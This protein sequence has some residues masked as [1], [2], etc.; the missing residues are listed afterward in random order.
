MSFIDRLAHAWNVF[1]NKDPT[2]NLGPSYYVRP[3][4]TRYSRGNERSIVTAIFN[5][6]AMDASAIDIRHVR[7]DDEGRFIEYVDSELDK[8]LTIEANIDQSGRSFRQDIY[9]SL[10]DEGCIGIVPVE[11]KDSKINGPNLYDV[12]SFRVGRILQW[13]PEHVKLEVYNEKTGKKEQVTLPK[14]QVA[15]VENPWYSVFNEP[16]S[17]MQRLIRKLNM[18][19]AI[20]EQNANGKLDMIIQLP[21]TVK[22]ELRKNQAEERRHSLEEQLKNTKYGVAY[23][24]S[25]EKIT[26]LNRPLENNMLKQIE[27]LTDMLYSQLGINKEILNGTANEQAMLNYNNR[28]IEPI[29]ASVADEMKRKFLTKTARTQGQTIMYFRD[30]FKLVPLDNLAKIADTFTRN[31]I[32]TS[33]EIRQIIGMKPADDPNADMLRNKNISEPG[34]GPMMDQQMA[35]DQMPYGEESEIQNEQEV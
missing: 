18:L 17:T 25:T 21:Y 6:I 31:E 26:Q 19:D 15:I 2:I 14:K 4:R 20:D 9:S 32:L 8:C 12:T 35:P 22:S 27:Y 34:G 23:I 5:R 11:F 29:V 16:N 3:D 24:D 33:N 7:V 30:P 28:T 1:K 13:Y 10:L